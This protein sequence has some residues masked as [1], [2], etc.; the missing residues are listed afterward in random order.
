MPTPKMDRKTMQSAVDTVARFGEQ[1][2]A[3][4]YLGISRTTLQSRIYKAKEAGIVPSTSTPAVSHKREDS[5][6]HGKVRGFL[7]TGRYTTADI[8]KRFDVT[9]SVV[10]EAVKALR[11]SGANVYEDA[12]LFSIEKTPVPVAF[13]DDLHTFKSDKDGVYR[14][15]FV[16]DNHLGSKYAR[17]DVLHDLYDFFVREGVS[18]VYNAGNWI[19]GEARFNRF[20]LK[21]HGMSAQLRY[22][23]ERYPQREG[24]TTYYIA[25][26]D[27]EGWYANKQGIDI[28]RHA[29]QVAR[30]EY[31]RND[32][33]YL[34]YMEAYI[35]L[36]H[37]RTGALSRMLV[38]HPGG[39]SA[40]AVSY[41][42][43]KLIESLDGGEKPAVAL[44]GHYHKMDA[45]NYRNV[46]IVQGGTTEDQTPFMRKLK[47]QAHVG[48]LLMELHQDEKGA[49]TDCIPWMKRYFDRGYYNDSFNPAGPV[50]RKCA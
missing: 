4:R 50:V 41:S 1:I 32:L 15:G 8:A 38:V 35:K 14:F 45:F 31:G 22:F 19:D 20:D 18:R 30:D 13:R 27:H 48:G 36:I 26:D 21:V 24:I 33:R 12:G 5:E 39:G 2:E 10:R 29:E 47:I 25:G 11:E 43:Q 40:Y 7:S 42:P 23:A 9:R 44:L 3:A 49:I 37:A 16:T 34:G 17:E 6:L 28:G 46:W